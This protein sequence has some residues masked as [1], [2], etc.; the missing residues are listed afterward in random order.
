M[1]V[2]QN[3]E[4]AITDLIDYKIVTACI[5]RSHDGNFSIFLNKLELVIQK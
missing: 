3:F 2:E 5:Y 1:N 4:M